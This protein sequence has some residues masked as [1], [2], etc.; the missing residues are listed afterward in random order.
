VCKKLLA[1]KRVFIFGLLAFGLA[2]PIPIPN[3]HG[4][5]TYIGL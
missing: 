1:W 4:F 3:F 2:T 5:N